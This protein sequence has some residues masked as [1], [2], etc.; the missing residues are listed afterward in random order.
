MRAIFIDSQPRLL[1]KHF[2]I[3]FILIVY[4]LTLPTSCSLRTKQDISSSPQITVIENKEEENLDHL[5]PYER[6]KTLITRS[7]ELQ[8]KSQQN[9]MELVSN[10]E[11]QSLPE[12]SSSPSTQAE[13]PFQKT[14]QT[15]QALAKS[16]ERVRKEGESFYDIQEGQI[17]LLKDQKKQSDQFRTNLK[18]RRK[19]RLL[20]LSLKEAAI[21]TGTVYKNLKKTWPH[22]IKLSNSKLPSSQEQGLEKF[23]WELERVDKK[24]KQFQFHTK[25]FPQNPPSSLSR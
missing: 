18:D 2:Q 9:L 24:I 13:D 23:R 16:I 4:G 5:P 8:L 3:S 10:S 1:R 6:L 15:L 22:G 17:L 14:K 19:F 21:Q 11:L 12:H 20:Y 25:A 7:E